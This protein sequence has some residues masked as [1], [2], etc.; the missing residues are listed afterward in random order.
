MSR[1]L[2]KPE[3]AQLLLTIEQQF[4]G[5]ELWA[6]RWILIIDGKPLPVGGNSKDGD[7]RFGRGAAT[8]QKGYKLHAVWGS[9]PLPIAWALAPLSTSEKTLARELIP[10]LPAGGYLLAD[11]E[12]DCAPLYDLAAKAGYQLVAEKRWKGRT[13]L[14]HRRQSPHRLR[15]IQLLR[16]RFGHDLFQVRPAIERCFG[17][18]TSFGGG[19]SPLPAWVRRFHRVRNWVHAK[20][21]LNATRFCR[22]HQIN[23]LS[24][25]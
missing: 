13:G 4:L 6:C 25:A 20:L 5:L 23:L 21:L 14:G 11:S 24:N 15:S 7:A 19:L 2:R 12:Y 3:V 9:G 8:I 17:N 10:T 18:C 1:R 16:S 22:T